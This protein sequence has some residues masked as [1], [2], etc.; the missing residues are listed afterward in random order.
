MKIL[1]KNISWNEVEQNM[2]I[3]SE[4]VAICTFLFTPYLNVNSNAEIHVP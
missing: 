4:R 3:I 2:Y 1:D